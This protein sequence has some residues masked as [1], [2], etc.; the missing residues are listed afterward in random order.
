MGY[1]PWGLT[2][3]DMTEQLTLLRR[4][5]TSYG[6]GLASAGEQ[7]TGWR[8]LGLQGAWSQEAP[9]SPEPQAALTEKQSCLWNLIT[10]QAKEKLRTALE[11]KG[12]HILLSSEMEDIETWEEGAPG[13]GSTAPLP[14]NKLHPGPWAPLKPASDSRCLWPDQAVCVYVLGSRG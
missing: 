9:A 7:G 3:S 4:A 8:A 2:E 12:L 10:P 11:Q 6:T 13:M 5:Y 1:S 14:Q